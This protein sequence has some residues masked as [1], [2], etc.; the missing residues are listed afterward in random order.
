MVNHNDLFRPS[1]NADFAANCPTGPCAPN[2]YRI[3]F[4]N[5]AVVRRHKSGRKNIGKKQNLF[6]VNRIGNFQRSDIGKRNARVFG[7]TA[8]EIRPLNAKNRK[9][10]NRQNRKAFP[11]LRVSDSSCRKSKTYRAGRKSSFRRRL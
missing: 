3:A 9:V 1:I 2:R 7:L 8:R 11:V 4:L 5:V 6:V 10:P